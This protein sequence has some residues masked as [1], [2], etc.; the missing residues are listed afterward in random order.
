AS[1]CRLAPAME[2]VTPTASR[3]W[4]APHQSAAAELRKNIRW[5][6]TRIAPQSASTKATTRM[7]VGMSMATSVPY[8]AVAALSLRYLRVRRVR[9]LRAIASIRRPAPPA[10]AAPAGHCRPPPRGCA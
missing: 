3:T 1:D 8:D 7:T 10:P 9:E 6:N 2:T 4:E 5:E